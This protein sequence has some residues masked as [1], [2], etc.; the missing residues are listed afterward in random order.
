MTSADVR[1]RLTHALRLD[2]IGPEPDELQA[3]ETLPISPSRF[4][5]TGFLAP[6]NAPAAQKADDDEQGELELAAASGGSE[7]DDSTPEPP[8][9]KRGQFPS[10]MGLSVLVLPGVK[11]LR[12]AA[13]WGDYEPV[14]R[15]GKAT[16]DWKRTERSESLSVSV[17]AEQSRPV[18]KPL[19]EGDGL[20]VVTSVRRVR[21]LEELPG[22]GVSAEQQRQAALPTVRGI[23]RACA[24]ET[25]TRSGGLRPS[26]GSGCPQV[27]GWTVAPRR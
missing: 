25:A 24:V 3:D 18:S 22:C 26:A 4:Y 21:G 7:D 15:E 16:S 5:L 12:V 14:G 20:E 2:L 6:L 11:T 8:A 23:R 9:A 17:A 19:V 27:Q 10:S 1:A 13:R